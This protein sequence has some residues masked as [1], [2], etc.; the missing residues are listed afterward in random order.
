MVAVR[1]SSKVAKAAIRHVVSGVLE[2]FRRRQ[3]AR[4]FP[5][6]HL[7]IFNIATPAQPDITNAQRGKFPLTRQNLAIVFAIANASLLRL[8]YALPFANA[9]RH[10]NDAYLAF[11]EPDPSDFPGT[12]HQCLPPV[13]HTYALLPMDILREL[14]MSED[15]MD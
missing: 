2:K 12:R 15:D 11:A 4:L 10:S 14:D 6:T 1:F 3:A 8:R 13:S 5:R 9:L 7:R